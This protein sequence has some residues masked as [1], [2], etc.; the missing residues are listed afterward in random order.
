[1]TK[2]RF[3]VLGCGHGAHTMAGHLAL[4]GMDVSIVG[5]DPVD[6]ERVKDIREMGGIELKGA[7]E[8]FAKIPPENATL[9]V[10]DGIKGRDVILVVVPATA[11]EYFFN[12]LARFI[13]E[14]QYIIIIPG[15]FGSLRLLKII[16]DLRGISQARK[17][18]IAETS[19]L[20]Y[21]CRLAGKAL[22]NVFAVKDPGTVPL[23]SIPADRTREVI[24]LL[25]RE[26]YEFKE[27]SN[28]LEVALNNINFPIHPTVS[29]FTLSLIEYTKGDYDFYGMGVTPAVAR[30][31][32]EVDKER[33]RVGEALGLNLPS[34]FNLITSMYKSSGLRGKDIYELL[35][36]SP[37]H[38][39]TKGP[40]SLTHRYVMEDIPFGLAPILSLCKYLKLECPVIESII[41]LWCIATGE[42]LMKKGV[43]IE[44]LGF[45][46]LSAEE[47]MRLVRQGYA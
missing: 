41:R 12:K 30:I 4:R 7:V 10:E 45:T 31:I 2:A 42:D 20:P 17:V 6:G 35:S 25:K 40:N 46:G 32:E 39:G 5:A 14:D 36:K 1:M 22:V 34:L 8:G 24:E 44:E 21:A 37:V 13:E 18:V 27:G 29:L 19:S 38:T 47:I 43:I 26:F 11:H 16:R 28:V 3:A 15:N 23:A 33:R 9:S